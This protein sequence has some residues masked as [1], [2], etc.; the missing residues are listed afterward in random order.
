MFRSVFF[1]H[2][3][4]D[5]IVY[6]GFAGHIFLEEVPNVIKVRIIADF[7]KRIR[8][9]MLRD[10]IDYDEA[11]KRLTQQDKKRAKWTKH[12]FGKD[13]HDPRLY[14]IYL[15]LHHISVDVA[16][17]SLACGD[18]DDDG[19]RDIA[20]GVFSTEQGTLPGGALEGA[21]ILWGNEQ[22]EFETGNSTFLEL[23]VCEDR[24]GDPCTSRTY[25]TGGPLLSPDQ[26]DLVVV[27]A[28]SGTIR[29]YPSS[30]T[31]EWYEP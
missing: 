29:I 21:F 30:H 20:A 13:H 17:S 5:N 27:G 15:N 12:L 16:V 23:P 28:E 31:R 18:F 24:N 14:D 25:V 9:R 2:M 26:D 4:K 7:E 1:E 22:G 19:I 6:H 11:R 10:H 8:E 3:S